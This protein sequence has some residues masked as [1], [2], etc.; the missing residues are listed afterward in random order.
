MGNLLQAKPVRTNESERC[1][2]NTREVLVVLFFN[3]LICTLVAVFIWRFFQGD[4]EQSFLFSWVYSQ[5]I[6]QTICIASL[7][8]SHFLK[9]HSVQSKFARVFGYCL[10]VP[11]GFYLGEVMAATILSNPVVTPNDGH[12]FWNSLLVSIFVSLFSVLFY[13]TWSHVT[14]LKLAAAEESARASRARL[15]MLQ[16]QVEPHMLFNTLSNLRS[17]IDS[18]PIKAQRM[19]DHFVDY[20]RA[21][22]A[23]S[24]HDTASLKEEFE[25]L[26][27]YLSLMEI[28]MGERLSFNLD[29]PK[30]LNGLQVPVLILQPIVENAIVHGLEPSID[31]G[32]ISVVARA[33][34]AFV[35]VEIIDTGV[36]YHP[37]VQEPTS[38]FGLQS[39]RER[40]QTVQTDCE[41][42]SISSPAEN[43]TVGTQV[44]IRFALIKQP[45]FETQT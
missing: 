15:S 30:T 27:T 11:L 10:I 25:L 42:L 16:A 5:C 6:G 18:D 23:G 43:S 19:M 24:Q 14:T 32:H 29:L 31:G 28:R 9:Q 20:L 38:G 26:E 8:Y 34:D 12:I 2:R 1:H 13:G 39:V 45:A 7:V 40:L 17:L 44:T 33:A 37:V 41:V 22:L 36:G 35:E 21:T 3:T 4:S